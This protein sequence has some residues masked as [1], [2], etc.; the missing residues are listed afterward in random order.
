MTCTL[1]TTPNSNNNDNINNISII[2]TD[3]LDRMRQ[4]EYAVKEN[5]MLGYR[6]AD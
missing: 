3:F 2:S 5:E 6:G 4:F 1:S